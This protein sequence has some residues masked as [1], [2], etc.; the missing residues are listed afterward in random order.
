MINKKNRKLFYEST[1]VI[2]M[3]L[4]F[5]S[6]YFA[7]RTLIDFITPISIF[8][9]FGLIVFFMERKNYN[10]T[11]NYH[12]YSFSFMHLT[13]S[14][15]GFALFLFFFLN[16]S[17]RSNEVKIQEYEILD[18]YSSNGGKGER[19]ILHPNYIIN[20]RNNK[21]TISF[22]KEFYS[23]MNSSKKIVLKTSKGFFGFEIL[24]NQT[25]KK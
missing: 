23:E 3:I 18:R 6:L 8:L 21:K 16:Y 19:D 12:G 1:F 11:Y 14:F 24:L 13:S 4:F 15:G 2:G 9:I 22:P 5:A 20:Y 17:I 25:L 7:S 10:D